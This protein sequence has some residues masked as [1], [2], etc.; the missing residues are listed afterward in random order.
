MFAIEIVKNMNYAKRL[1]IGSCIFYCKRQII[2]LYVF[3]FLICK[4]KWT[5]MWIFTHFHN[6][7]S[8]LKKVLAKPLFSLLPVKCAQW[9]RSDF[10]QV[11]RGW[12]AQGAHRRGLAW[13]GRGQRP[14]YQLASSERWRWAPEG[15]S[16]SHPWIHLCL[17]ASARASNPSG[18]GGG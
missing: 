17:Q 6:L 3:F 5:L 10:I 18:L 11:Q 1:T 8:F 13:A 14:G 15:P 9:I 2:V 4:T 7:V 16:P 12:W